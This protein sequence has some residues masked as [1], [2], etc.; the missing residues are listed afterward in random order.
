MDFIWVLNRECGGYGGRNACG[1][2]CAES[3]ILDCERYSQEDYQKRKTYFKNRK[4]AENYALPIAK[5]AWETFI[6]DMK[7]N[8]D[9]DE[10]GEDC[11]AEWE[12]RGFHMVQL[13]KLEVWD[14]FYELYKS[15]EEITSFICPIENEYDRIGYYFGGISKELIY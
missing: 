5:L 7:S 1:F 4:D 8:N 6:Q 2:I 12:K 3:K 15:K 14:L 13:D 10:D 11:T 9:D